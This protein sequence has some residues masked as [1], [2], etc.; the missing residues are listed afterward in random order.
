MFT[1]RFKTQELALVHAF[2]ISRWTRT[3][4]KNV[5]VELE[6]DGVIGIGEAS[7]NARYQES[8]ETAEAFLASLDFS[9]WRNPYDVTELITYL[10]SVKKGEYAA[11]AAV[12]MAFWDWM[13]KK[14]NL[15]IHKL[16]NA[17]T[18]IGP[19]SSFTIGIDS[20][21]IIRQKV[22]EASSFPI[23]KVK[24]GTDNDENVINLIRSL[25]DKTIWADANE[26]WKTLDIAKKRIE[27]LQDKNIGMIEQPMPSA[28][29][30]EIAELKKLTSIPLMADEGFTG[31]ETL[32]EL[33]H[34]Y[35]GI[36]IKL[37]KIGSMHK[38]MQT[39]SNA[40]KLGLKIMIG[41]M[42][43]TALANTAA[44]ILSM[45][46]DYADIDGFLLLKDRP[47]TGFTFDSENRVVLNNLP[48][49]GVI[50]S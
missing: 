30:N 50:N 11:K 40:R 37:M 25:T 31:T 20:E 1:L 32:E 14:L 10:N 5:F 12:E 17:P 3:H 24:L 38:A 39:I 44:G 46:A 43:E 13:G 45:W 15:P 34:N 4:V 9:N 7:P 41:C 48:G 33:A 42:I 29:S 35:T 23:L 47:Y 49:L 8:H 2:G 6:A 18:D 26:G 22:E 27:F 21:V 16:W 36:N 28:Q 19:V